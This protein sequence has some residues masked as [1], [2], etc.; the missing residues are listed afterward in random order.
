MTLTFQEE[1]EN[2]PHLSGRASKMTL[3]FQEDR[4]ESQKLV[5]GDEAVVVGIGQQE[6][7]AYEDGGRL[8]A[9]RFRELRACQL[10]VHHGVHTGRVKAAEMVA[11]F[12][13]CLRMCV[14]D[15]QTTRSR[16]SIVLTKGYGPFTT[17]VYGPLTARCTISCYRK[18]QNVM[19][20]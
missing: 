13:H 20:P 19:L 12:G 17:M 9:Q 10:D 6:D 14:T 8:H 4:E 5:E 7:V 15:G 1:P 2:D 18:P 11:I 16:V 3:T